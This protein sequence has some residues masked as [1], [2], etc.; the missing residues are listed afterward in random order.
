MNYEWR[1]VPVTPAAPITHA[2]EWYQSGNMGT[3]HSVLTAANTPALVYGMGVTKGKIVQRIPRYTAVLVEGAEG[4]YVEAKD[5]TAETNFGR[6]EKYHGDVG[7][8]SGTSL[9]AAA[10]HLLDK[11]AGSRT[12]IQVT[13]LADDAYPRPLV[14]Y[15]VGDTVNTTLLPIVT[16]T[17]KR[18][19]QIAYQNS[20]PPEYQITVVAP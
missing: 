16:R 7:L 5:A 17:G 19:E 20:E 4:A 15:T 6:L 1:L 18:V 13:V 11:E 9:T 10:Q 8:T 2:L 12:S 3:D 14:H